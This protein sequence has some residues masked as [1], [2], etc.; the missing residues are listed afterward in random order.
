MAPSG[1]SAINIEETAINTALAIPTEAGEN[2]PAMSDQN[3]TQMRLS[4]SELRLI[5]IDE[6]SMVFNIR[7]L[8]IHQ[9]LKDIFCSSSSQLFAGISVVFV[10]DFYQLTPIRTKLIFENLKNNYYN[11][12]HPCLVF[13]MIELTEIM[14]QKDDHHFIQ[15][16]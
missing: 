12:Y 2:L 8:E 16:S 11:V 7:V 1:V 10:G 14:R 5:I 3:K 13:R 9:R 4:L 15:Q 6:V